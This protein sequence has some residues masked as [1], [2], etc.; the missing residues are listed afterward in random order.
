MS[1]GAVAGAGPA[2]PAGPREVP[3]AERPLRILHARVFDG[4]ALRDAEETVLVAGGRIV[5]A[6]AWERHPAAA[7]AGA[8]IETVDARGGI[9][10]PGLI[11]AHFHAYG[12]S[13]SLFHNDIQLPSYLAFAAQRRLN[14]ALRRGFTTVRDVCGGDR[15]IARAIAEGLLSSPRYVYS[16]PALSQTGGHGDPTSPDETLCFHAGPGLEVVD[17]ADEVRRAVRAR[18]KSGA[19]V[20]KVMASGGVTS[21]ADPI[22][23]PQFSAEEIGVAVEEAERRGLYVAAHAYSSEAVRHALAAG[24]RSIEHGNLIDAETAAQLRDRGAFLVP[25]LITYDAMRRRG[26]AHGLGPA[27]LRKNGEVLEA[28]RSAIEHCV[29]QGARVGFGTDLMGPLEDE[30]LHGLRLQSEVM[31]VEATLRAATSTN[32]E[33][34]RRPDLGR[35]APGASADLLIFDGDPLERPELLWDERSRAVV[36][37]GRVRA[38]VG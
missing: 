30:Q 23:V 32:A 12:I 3:P 21:P 33:L 16:G 17:G 13:L 8:D 29:A 31:G 15:G 26:E 36:Q 6:E 14:G 25:T 38:A 7:G 24:V 35:V 28:G 2:Q 10:T 27:G 20:I 19:G 37:A 22:A 11:D 4:V 34:L 9:V 1:G 18:I 5:D